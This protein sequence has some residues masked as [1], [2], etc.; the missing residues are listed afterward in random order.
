MAKDERIYAADTAGL[1]YF[2]GLAPQGVK[3]VLD[4]RPP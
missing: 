3:W 4:S 2:E 1:E